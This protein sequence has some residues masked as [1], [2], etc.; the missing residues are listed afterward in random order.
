MKFVRSSSFSTYRGSF[1][2]LRDVSI[3]L[4]V[5]SF[6]SS[7]DSSRRSFTSRSP[8]SKEESKFSK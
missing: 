3:R 4:K 5:N 8:S 1:C 6:D 7:I 2:R